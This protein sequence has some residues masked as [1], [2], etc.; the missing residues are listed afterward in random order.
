MENQIPDVELT[1]VQR[2]KSYC[3]RWP[4]IIFKDRQ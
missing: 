2:K 3:E 4:R 1:E